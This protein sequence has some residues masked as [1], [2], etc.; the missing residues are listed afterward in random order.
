MEDGQLDAV[1]SIKKPTTLRK[2]RGLIGLMNWN[3]YFIPDFSK[4]AEPILTLLKSKNIKR[5]WTDTHD[6]CLQQLKVAFVSEETLA[7]P[8]FEKPFVLYTDASEFCVGGVLCQETTNKG[9]KLAQPIAYFS[10]LM[11]SGQKNYSVDQGNRSG[12]EAT[13]ILSF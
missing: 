13:V 6:S 2:L 12:E 8:N 1:S 5:D 3:R 9:N 10:R 7:H 4:L 11:N